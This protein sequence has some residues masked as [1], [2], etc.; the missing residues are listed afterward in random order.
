MKSLIKMISALAFLIQSL[1]MPAFA[2]SEE[3]ATICEACADRHLHPGDVVTVNDVHYMVDHLGHVD[4]KPMWISE[5]IDSR[6]GSPG[7]GSGGADRPGNSRLTGKDFSAYEDS[8]HYSEEDRAIIAQNQAAIIHRINEETTADADATVVELDKQAQQIR[9]AGTNGVEVLALLAK[10]DV[11]MPDPMTSLLSTIKTATP[12]YLDEAG[13]QVYQDHPFRSDHKDELESLRARLNIALP[14]SPQQADAKST[15]YVLLDAADDAYVKSDVALG[16][17]IVKIA[18]ITIDIAT[19]IIPLTAIPKDFYRAVVGKDPRTGESLA[20]WE[21]GLAA[22]LLAVG[23]VTLGASNIAAP[24]VRAIAMAAHVSEAEV[25]TASALARDPNATKYTAAL[26]AEAKSKLTEIHALN[27]AVENATLK[28][29]RG[30]EHLAWDE[31]KP[32]L[33]GMT[34]QEEK[35]VRFF[36]DSQYLE[37]SW[38]AAE[39][40]VLGK[41]PA[42]IKNIFALKE[43]PTHFVEVRVPE[44][45]EL[46]IG[47]V[48]RNDWGGA[49]GTLQYFIAKSKNA[50]FGEV[51]T[52]GGFF[53]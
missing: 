33:A 30:Y 41:T 46:S 29:V 50:R 13:W 53:K 27:P 21:R 14:R 8:S 2:S 44:R 3:Y 39:K 32:L 20:T 17:R 25:A 40:D 26:I 34:I 9:D 6:G 48:G 15:G 52:L 22:G 5:R 36:S 49:D 18:K 16:D 1:A 23:L 37:G 31:G 28:R 11:A 10:A 45:V 38:V 35:F 42:E 7:P 4:G 12:I 51:Q 47:Y 19:D 24:E 43:N